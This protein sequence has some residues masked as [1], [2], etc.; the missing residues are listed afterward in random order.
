MNFEHFQNYLPLL[1][2][3]HQRSKDGVIMDSIKLHYG[4]NDGNNKLLP[5]QDNLFRAYQYLNKFFAP[6]VSYTDLALFIV[7][8]CHIICTELA[9]FF[10]SL[11]QERI[12]RY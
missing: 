1:A 8:S 3:L 5:E 2:L 6:V 11:F 10:L 7:S 4:M 12:S 9:F